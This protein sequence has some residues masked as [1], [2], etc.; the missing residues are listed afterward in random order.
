MCRLLI[1]L[2]IGVLSAAQGIETPS[3]FVTKNCAGCHNEKLKSG[4][5]SWTKVDVA[6]PDLT[7]AEAE[8]AIH[9]LRVGM[10]P[11][12]GVPRPEAGAVKAFAESLEAKIDQSAAAHPNP[13][14][15]ALHR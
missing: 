11:P 10:M 13:G 4:G 7:A 3:A 14:S 6:H 1:G 2:G 5:F 15:P 12:P 9:M 8:K